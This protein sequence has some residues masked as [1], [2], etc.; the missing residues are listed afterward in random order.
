MIEYEYRCKN[1]K[2]FKL[3]DN[4]TGLGFCSNNPNESVLDVTPKNRRVNCKF[5]NKK[6]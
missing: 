1:C 5:E 6:N 4:Q 2:K 3:M